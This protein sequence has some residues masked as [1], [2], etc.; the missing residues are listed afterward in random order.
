MLGV[1]CRV[2]ILDFLQPIIIG[3]LCLYAAVNLIIR[4]L[5]PA[6]LELLR[7]IFFSEVVFVYGREVETMLGGM[8]ATDGFFAQKHLPKFFLLVVGVVAF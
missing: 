4:I 3:D 8:R 2:V 7:V 6:A 1:C 5:V